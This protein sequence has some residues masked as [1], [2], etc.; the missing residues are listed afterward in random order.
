MADKDCVITFLNITHAMK[1]EKKM[2]EMNIGMKIIPVPRS[3]SSSCG[4][5]GRFDCLLKTEIKKHCHQFEINFDGIYRIYPM[6]VESL[7]NGEPKNPVDDN[8]K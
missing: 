3:I 6:N 4:V 7:D 5:C 8:N 2:K 1:F